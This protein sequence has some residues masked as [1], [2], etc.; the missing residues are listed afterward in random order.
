MK[1][2]TALVAVAAFAAAPAFAGS[3]TIEFAAEGAEPVVAVMDQD[4]GTATVGDKT[5]PYT[6]DAAT[7]TLCI[8]SEEGIC[9]TFEGDPQDPVVGYSSSF[10]AT[11][12]D[13][14]VA[15]IVA[16]D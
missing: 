3:F 8:E 11:N 12:G 14:G 15:T 6:F 5:A 9:A 1:K 2:I 13:A 4:A 10:T 7:N 16:V